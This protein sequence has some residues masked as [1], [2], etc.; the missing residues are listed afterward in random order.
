[1]QGLANFSK[2]VALGN[3]EKEL[4]HTHTHTYLSNEY[5]GKLLASSAQA[6]GLSV[7]MV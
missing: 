1:M 7:L 2:P 6:Q 4:T 5:L 3:M